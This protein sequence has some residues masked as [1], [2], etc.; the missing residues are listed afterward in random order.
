[1]I[2]P[3]D[4]KQQAIK[5]WKPFL[6]SY[7]LKEPFFPKEIDRIGKARPADLTQRFDVLQNEIAALYSKSKNETGT[8][9]LIKTAEKNY[10][11]TGVHQLPHSVVFETADDYLHFTRKKTEWEF[12]IRNYELLINN[13]PQLRPWII[14]NTIFL[15]EPGTDWEGILSACKY[16][17][18]TPRPEL[19]LRQLPIAVHTKFIEEN[20]SLIQ[21]LLDFLIPE[22][23]KD[24]SQKKF[25]DRYYLQKDEPLIRIRM[26]DDSL[27]IT[28]NIKDFSIRLSDFEK[29]LWHNK[30]VVITEN[31]M[32]FL[33]LPPFPSAIAIW[34][35]G[36]FKVSY[37]KNALWL[38][39]KN[40]YYWG[41]IDEHGFLI[42]HQLRSYYGQ[43][44]SIMMDRQTF[45]QFHQFTVIG[46]RNN[47]NKLDLLNEDEAN[48]YKI[49]K[50][51]QNNNRLEQEKISQNYVEA[52]FSRLRS[53]I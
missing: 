31:K 38:A 12:F 42:L 29:G 49:L 15:T 1:M 25:D 2:S 27:A 28:N 23:I 18:S 33:T 10:R 52:I 48:L 32:N 44:K 5:W 16:F 34:S 13:L 40:I 8:G 17:I 22:H 36:G 7:I 3:E 39:D 41:D 11:R 47:I 20:V 19:Y 21:S 26:L 53:I 9:Y 6:Q 4:I 43:V 50:S 14:E 30:N 24:K 46:E 37:L 45:D 35:G 51:R